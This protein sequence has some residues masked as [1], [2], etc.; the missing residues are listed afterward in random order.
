MYI[1]PAKAC[2]C[3]SGVGAGDPDALETYKAIG[4]I[5]YLRNTGLAPLEKNKAI[6]HSKVIHHRPAS[7]PP[8]KWRFAGGSMMAC[9]QW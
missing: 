4:S 6:K 7:E 8:L 5:G 2:R 9:F 3:H 1:R